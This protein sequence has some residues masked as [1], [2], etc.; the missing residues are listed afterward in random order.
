[1][2]TMTVDSNVQQ[3]IDELKHKLR[4]AEKDYT[5]KTDRESKLRDGV[6]KKKDYSGALKGLLDQ[7]L[8]TS[9]LGIA[10]I[11]LLRRARKQAEKVGRNAGLGISAIE[12]MICETEKTINCTEQ[13]F[14]YIRQLTDRIEHCK[15]AVTDEKKSVTGVAKQLRIEIEKAIVN[16]VELLKALYK[17]LELQEEVSVVISAKRGLA[18]ELNAQ[19]FHMKYG[20]RNDPS[21]TDDPEDLAEC[22]SCTKRDKPIFPMNDPQC[23]VYTRLHN[24]YEAEKTALAKLQEALESATGEREKAQAKKEALDAALKAALAAKSCESK[25]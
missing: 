20:T 11:K 4:E 19:K 8:S 5:Q 24:A 23:D 7:M 16:T 25:N 6:Q 3:Y 14:I 9:D 18:Y 13:L 2:D 17:A 22:A 1:M 10:H 21:D 12:I 15:V